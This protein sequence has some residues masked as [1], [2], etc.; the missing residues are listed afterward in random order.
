MI[1]RTWITLSTAW[2]VFW[3]YLYVVTPPGT[4]DEQLTRRA[5]LTL[6]MALPWLTG[7]ILYWLL[8]GA[9]RLI[10]RAARY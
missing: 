3:V 2:C 9:G 7:V 8:V 4:S 6:V 5:I 10:A 1:R